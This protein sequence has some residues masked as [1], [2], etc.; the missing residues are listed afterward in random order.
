M[1]ETIKLTG[2]VKYTLIDK[3]GMV[4][5]TYEDHNLVVVVGKSYLAQFL[6][7]DPQTGT[8]MPY[9]GLGTSSAVPSPSD[10]NLTSP[11]PTRI[12]GTL[13][14]VSNTWNNSVSFPATIDTGD[15]TEAGLFSAV[16]G[17]TMFSHQVFTVFHKDVS[18][19]FNVNWTVTF[20]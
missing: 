12:R 9:V 13:S 2:Y 8:F 15:I 17:G 1:D 16:T 19:S 11:L 3:N 6:A 7:T 10:V 18:D 20:S 5:Q 14:S 4:K